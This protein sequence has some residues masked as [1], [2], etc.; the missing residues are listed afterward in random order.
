MALGA[1]G[2]FLIRHLVHG[3]G[4]VVTVAVIA[5]IMLARLW[6]L[7]VSWIERHRR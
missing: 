3:K 5:A 7:L 6:P 4:L 2:G 1:G